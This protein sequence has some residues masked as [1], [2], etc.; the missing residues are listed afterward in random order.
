MRTS[1]APR[2]PP[3]RAV[4][5]MVIKW[6]PKVRIMLMPSVGSLRNMTVR[7][8]AVQCLCG[9]GTSTVQCGL[10][11]MQRVSAQLAAERAARDSEDSGGFLLM[12]GGALERF[13]NQILLHFLQRR[14]AVGRAQAGTT[15]LDRC[16]QFMR[17]D[18]LI[19]REYGGREHYV[20]QLAHISAP[21]IVL[22]SR[23]CFFRKIEM[24][25]STV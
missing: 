9:W 5:M 24:R 19:D 25:I 3:S 6:R 12:T 2:S 17:G 20:A 10:G 11:L 7:I 15:M 8:L 22:K 18:C 16:R 23:F 21:A 14:R 13:E 4:S 1:A